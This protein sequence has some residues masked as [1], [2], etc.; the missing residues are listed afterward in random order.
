MLTFIF[1][2]HCLYLYL[3]FISLFI[4]ILCLYFSYS[5]LFAVYSV[6]KSL[7]FRVRYTGTW[8]LLK[9]CHCSWTQIWTFSTQILGH[10]LLKCFWY[11][12]QTRLFFNPQ[13]KFTRTC[14]ISTLALKT[15]YNV[16]EFRCWCKCI[17]YKPCSFIYSQRHYFRTRLALHVSKSS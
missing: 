1:M 12:F 5:C 6:I 10:F 11:K 7:R 14:V 2:F 17:S 8:L 9:F 4:F 15:K 3:Y 13:N 16:A